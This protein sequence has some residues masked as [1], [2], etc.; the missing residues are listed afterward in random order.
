MSV[1]ELKKCCKCKEVKPLDL[2]YNC[3][4][5][6]DGKQQKCIE[7]IKWYAD[8]KRQKKIE[9]G[10]FHPRNDMK[11]VDIPKAVEMYQNG[12]RCEA[13]GKVLGYGRSTVRKYIKLQGIDVRHT[14]FRRKH[15]IIC[16][17]YFENI[18]SQ[19]KAYFLGLLWAD[20][21]NFRKDVKG[22]QAYQIVISLQEGDKHILEELCLKIF[23]NTNVMNFIKNMPPKQNSWNLRVP[24]VKIS[25][26]LLKHGMYP[27]KSITV[28]WPEN[29]DRSLWRHFLRGVYDG[30]GGISFNSNSFNYLVGIIGS[31]SFIDH[32]KLFLQEEFQINFHTKENIY[33]TGTI[34]KNFKIHG[35]DKCEKFLDW[36]YDGAIHKL[37]RKYQKYLDLKQ[38]ISDRNARKNP[39]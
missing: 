33:H 32:L 27:R 7:C 21:C 25:N 11:E 17:D 9:A 26:D 13:I 10:D 4:R 2:F 1:N 8:I 39:E 35:N 18:D 28:G 12:M 36:L 3:K 31:I 19:D 29:L 16:E 14:N 15:K 20:G 23:E 38:L 24:S 34:M 30:D 22:K 37:N 6:K 5:Y